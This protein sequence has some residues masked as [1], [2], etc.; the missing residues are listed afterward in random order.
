[1]TGSNY[2]PARQEDRALLEARHIKK[3]F[4]VRGDAIRHPSAIRAVDDVSFSIAKGTVLGLVGES[5][6]GKTTVGRIILNLIKPTEGSVFFDGEDITGCGRRMMR[7]VRRRL[8]I[9][10]QDPFSSLDPHMT[11]YD[12]VGEGI[13]NYKLAR[14]KADL[15]RQVECLA[16]KCG[17]SEDLCSR[18]PHQ[19]SGGQRQRICIA[20]ALATNPEF[21]VCDEAVSALD[22]SIQAQIINLLK[23]L[24]EDMG[25]TYLFVSH[26]LRVV[27]FISDEVAVM[28]LGK[29]LEKGSAEDVFRHPLH[30]YT[31]ALLSAAPAFTEEEK[32]AKKRII[33]E[34]DMPS[35]TNS[36]SGC[37]FSTRCPY[38]ERE[39]QTFAPEWGEVTPGHFAACHRVK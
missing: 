9:V 18:Y 33:L 26:D 16:V 39:C 29:I 28:Y 34:G 22:V 5:G 21:I 30:P 32:S 17:L 12:I 1:M 10:F 31:E 25:L 38:V 20:R 14:G 35:Q 23:E 6:C 19:F 3:Y 7:E 37:P 36:P 11:V 4:S 8:Q 24:Q 15:M 13:R 27:E 2:Q